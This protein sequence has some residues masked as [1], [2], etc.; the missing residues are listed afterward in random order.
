M[1][2]ADIACS[3]VRDVDHAQRG[4]SRLPRLLALATSVLVVVLALPTFAQND[5]DVLGLERGEHAGFR[6]L[7]DEDRSEP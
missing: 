4:R 6:L 1:N 3:L 7:E 2:V 5:A